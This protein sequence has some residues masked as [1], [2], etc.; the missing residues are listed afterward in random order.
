M[1]QINQTL[2]GEISYFVDGLPVDTGY[3]IPAG[4]H[5]LLAQF[6]GEGGFVVPSGGK[7]IRVTRKHIVLDAYDIN[8]TKAYDGTDSVLSL[9]TD[10]L[11]VGVVGNDDVRLASFSAKYNSAQVGTNKT[12]TVSMS[13]AGTD[14][15]NY[16]VGDEFLPGVIRKREVKLAAGDSTKVYD[17]TPLVFDSVAI[18][19]DGFIDR[20]SVV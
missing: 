9:R 7:S 5:S 20:K 18:I 11:L 15:A 3:V 14:T 8:P 1:A 16:E 2:D 4:T 10:S 6:S 17:G 12:I 19:G 13:L